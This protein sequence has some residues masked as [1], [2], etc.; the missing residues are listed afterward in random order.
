MIRHIPIVIFFILISIK[1]FSQ[2]VKLQKHPIDIKREQCHSIPANQ[3]TYGM[4]QCEATA[5][6]EWDKE[7]NKSVISI[8]AGFS[9][10]KTKI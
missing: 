8:D 10:G 6:T 2:E 3:T 5:Y 9:I 1:T 7:M 4:I